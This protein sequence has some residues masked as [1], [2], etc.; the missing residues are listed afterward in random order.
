MDE[1]ARTQNVGTP[2]LFITY[3]DGKKSIKKGPYFTLSYD[4]SGAVI[5]QN[6]VAYQAFTQDLQFQRIIV[7]TYHSIIAT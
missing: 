7:P 5:G 4:G 1:S 6:W 2:R 3:L